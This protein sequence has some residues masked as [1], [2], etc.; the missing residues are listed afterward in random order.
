MQ[1]LLVLREA[2]LCACSI[3]EPRKVK[4]TQHIW[5]YRILPRILWSRAHPHPHVTDKLTEIQNLFK[6]VLNLKGPRK[7]STTSGHRDTYARDHREQ[8]PQERSGQLTWCISSHQQRN[9][10]CLQA[11]AHQGG[12]L[13]TSSPPPSSCCCFCCCCYR[14]RFQP[15]FFIG[16]LIACLV[17]KAP[18][19][20]HRDSI[21]TYLL[22]TR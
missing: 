1:L 22:S 5:F 6:C 3:H 19:C 2:D 21:K 12:L 9:V 11:V 20:V 13:P 7:N 4:G 14:S 15:P 16:S 18:E 17:P 10:G 8:T